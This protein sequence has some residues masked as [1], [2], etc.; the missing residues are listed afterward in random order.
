[1]P[2]TIRPANAQDAAR[3]TEIL[4]N[5]RATYLPFAISPHTDAAM[6]QWVGE[7]LLPRA[8]C[9][10]AQDEQGTLLGILAL[11][12][13]ATGNWIDQLYLCP[14]HVGQGIGK[15]LLQLAIERLSLPIR[16]YTFQQN[17]GAR[18]FYERYGFQAIAWSNGAANEERCA[19]VLYE[20]AVPAALP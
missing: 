14:E 6:H 5:S 20:L 2:I 8:E 11:Q 16:L 4:I 13:D 19:D 17:F 9:F 10:V 18:R 7:Q 1:M 3:I 15:Q 12:S